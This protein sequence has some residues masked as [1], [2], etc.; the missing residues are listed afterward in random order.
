MF[1]QLSQMINVMCEFR[2]PSLIECY[3]YQTTNDMHVY[4]QVSKYTHYMVSSKELITKQLMEVNLFN[5]NF[6]S[7]KT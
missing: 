2:L 1:K 7:I 5:L 6:I 4:H 3:C